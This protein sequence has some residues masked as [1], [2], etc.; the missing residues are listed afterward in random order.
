MDTEGRHSAVFVHESI[1]DSPIRALV[2][3]HGVDLEDERSRMLV[4]QHRGPLPVLL[5][6]RGK[7]GDGQG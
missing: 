4:L 2:C 7:G 5:A 6:L 1:G 3:I